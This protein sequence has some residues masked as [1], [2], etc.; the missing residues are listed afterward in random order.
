[1]SQGM[2]SGVRVLDLTSVVIGPLCT[3]ILADH[4]A[5]VI[6]VESPQGDVGRHLG[7]RG[8]TPGMAPKFLH[9]NRNKRS[10]CLDLKHP[11]GYKALVE[12]IK[13]ADVMTWNVRPKSMQRMK[14]SYEEVKA[15]NPTIIYCGM[16]GF[17]QDG[18]YAEIPAYDQII[19][20]SSGVAGLNAKAF[21]EPRYLPY[22]LA[23][24]TGGLIA[25]Q[26]IAMALFNRERKGEGQSIQIPMFENMATQVLTEHLYNQ[27]YVPPIGGMGDPRLVNEFYAPSKTLD[28]YISI[29]ANTDAQVFPLFEAMGLGHLKTDEKFCSVAARFK[30]VHDYYS[31]RS[32]ELKKQTTAFWM[33]V[34]KKHDIPA[35][36]Y[37]TLET[38]IEDPHLS[39]VGLLVKR[40]HPSEGNILDIRPANEVSSGHREDWMPAPLLGQQ[41]VEI[42]K[43]AGLSEDTIQA[44]LSE[45]SAKEYRAS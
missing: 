1:M 34:C 40:Q 7:G 15:I 37:H 31:L 44:M 23:D 24:R 6:K 3:Q 45:G 10:I 16:F 38:L 32:S 17:G 25:V 12:L 20:G 9:L 19:Q 2:L 27:T 26:M 5:Q 33:E 43:E 11:S 21:G 29:S 30:N 39:D 4:G 18:R 8:K 28:S 35:A 22:V 41:T 42:L 14:L 13:T 36:P